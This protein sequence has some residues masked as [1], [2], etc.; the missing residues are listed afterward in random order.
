MNMLENLFVAARKL[1]F[2]T[3]QSTEGRVPT[4]SAGQ[5]KLH[6]PYLKQAIVIRTVF[7]IHSTYLVRQ[8]F[9]GKFSQFRFETCSTDSVLSLVP[10][11]EER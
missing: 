2:H 11:F 7:F 3:K 8:Q 5:F 6:P 10:T 1:A 4:F 9:I